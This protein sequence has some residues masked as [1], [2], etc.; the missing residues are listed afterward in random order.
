MHGGIEVE[1]LSDTMV[2][3]GIERGYSIMEK[4]LSNESGTGT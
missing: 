3:H 1:V 4:Y 2:Y